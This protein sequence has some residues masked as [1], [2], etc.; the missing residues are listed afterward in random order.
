[1]KEIRVR[2][3]PRT[4]EIEY[5]VS[6][7]P[8]ASCTDITDQLVGHDEVVEQKHTDEYYI[9]LPQPEFVGSGGDDDK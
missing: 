8:G 7:V 2:I 1:M 6:G 5:E 3:N 9:P 4:C